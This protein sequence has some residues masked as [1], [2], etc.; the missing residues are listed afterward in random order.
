M[1]K[2]KGFEKHPLSASELS[3]KTHEPTPGT[4]SNSKVTI[5]IRCTK[6]LSVIGQGH[7]HSCTQKTQKL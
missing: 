1:G 2:C 7:S 4:S 5:E 6:C 3:T